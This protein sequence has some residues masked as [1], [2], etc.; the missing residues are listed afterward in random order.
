MIVSR[1][2]EIDAAHY[3]PGYKGKCANLHGH[4]WKIEV[5][6]RG[7]YMHPGMVVDFN[8]L[9][10]PLDS[11]KESLDHKCI[12]DVIPNPTAEKIVEY[13]ADVFNTWLQEYAIEHAPTNFTL[14]WVKVWETEDSYA[15]LE[16]K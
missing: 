12:N 16:M 11:I 10:V 8:D 15:M 7:G 14:T 2:I 3:L 1:S 4:R 13:V 5:A 6:V 9:K